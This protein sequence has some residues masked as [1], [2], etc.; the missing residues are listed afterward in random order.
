MANAEKK[1]KKRDFSHLIA[2]EKLQDNRRKE[3]EQEKRRIVMAEK[4]GQMEAETACDTV[5]MRHQ[6]MNMSGHKAERI[7]GCCKTFRLRDWLTLVSGLVEC[8]CFAGVVFGWA[9]LVFVLKEDGYFSEFCVNS[10]GAN[11]TGAKNSVFTDC[12]AQDEQFAMIF[13]IASFLNSF[14]AFFLGY[15]FDR[16]GTTAA[17]IL[18]ISLYTTGTLLV[19]VSS[20]ATSS[21]ILP[22]TSLIDV[23]GILFLMT[24]IQVGNLFGRYRSTIITLYN[25]PYDSSSSIFLIFKVLHEQGVS[26]RSSFLFMSS[27]SVIHLLRTFFLLPKTH[28]PYPLPE[29]YTYG[30]SCSH[31]SLRLELT[32]MREAGVGEHVEGERGTQTDPSGGEALQQSEHTPVKDPSFRS[33]V[34]SGFFLAHLVW[35][36]LM[37]LRLFLFIDI[38]NPIVERLADGDP[39]LVSR[40][41]NA[42]GFTQLCG[43]FCAPWNG[44]LLDRQKKKW[45]AKGKTEKEAGLR[46]SALSLFITS[47]LCL[48][49]S[50][51]ASIPVLPLQ[52]LTF[53]LQ[54]VST[55]FLF[56][57]NAAF[58][59]IAFPSCHY[60]K[61]YGLMSTLSAVVLLLQF[62]LLMLVNDT[63][64]GD[65][66]YVNVG[67]TLLTLVTLIHPLYVHLH[68]RRLVSQRDCQPEATKPHFLYLS[69]GYVR[70]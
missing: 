33:C 40:Y 17:R 11:N 10:T 42:F 44:L 50:V 57:G 1:A 46:S 43:V 32:E 34:L 16:Y 60:G 58:I 14:F 7:L 48:L 69:P 20:P 59:S 65:P 12:S 64:Q 47:L 30:G 38:L 15:V 41:T 52:Y 54:V 4:D 18:G 28:I 68:C 2:S 56:G 66:L 6:P 62:P 31:P 36:S 8:L 24:N 49:F 25:G 27:C 51:C 39:A 5:V 23:G 19:A 21:L 35:L 63:L 9:S 67:L 29:N 22:A 53:A 3:R 55:S 70:F 37:Q 13:T 61:L 45:Q 26:L